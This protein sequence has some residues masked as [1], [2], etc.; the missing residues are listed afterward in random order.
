MRHLRKIVSPELSWMD[1]YFSLYFLV[2]CFHVN[3]K[4]LRE[5]Q[6]LRVGLAHKFITLFPSQQFAHIVNKKRLSLKTKVNY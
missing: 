1:D 6:K 5:P 2:V 3:K 4:L